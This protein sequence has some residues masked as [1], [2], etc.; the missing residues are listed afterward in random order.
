MDIHKLFDCE[1]DAYVYFE[2][3]DRGSCG[4]LRSMHIVHLHRTIA[5]MCPPHCASRTFIQQCAPD[6]CAYWS[7]RIVNEIVSWY[8]L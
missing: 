4:M 5:V 2:V 8:M 7:K 1:P 6:M 3:A